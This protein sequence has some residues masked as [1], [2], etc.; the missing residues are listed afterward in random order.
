VNRLLVLAP[1]WLGDVVMALPALTA[2]RAWWPGAH[3][4][5]AA[6]P[7]VAPLLEMIDG[8][9]E[10]IALERPSGAGS[11][12]AAGAD[13]ARLAAGRFE[14]VVLLP[15]SF[16]AAWLARQAG[17]REVWGFRTSGRGLLLTRAVPKPPGR[18][19]QAEYYRALVRGL[20][21]PEAPLAAALTVS[22]EQRARAEELL[23]SR[24]WTGGPIVS[25][26]PGAAYGLA[27]RWPPD[28]VAAVAVRLA[29]AR[30]ATPVL[31]GAPGDLDTIQEV[32]AHIERLVG[33]SAP[34]AVDLGGRTDLLTL[35][36]VLAM[37]RAVVSNDSGAMHVAA[38]VGVPVTAIFG[39]TNEHATAP[40]AH[41]SGRPIALVA[42]EAWCRPCQL[43]ICPIDHRCMKTIDPSRVAD[44]VLAHLDR[45]GAPV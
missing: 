12:V 4:A 11:K 16:H 33:A 14:A 24:G 29:D 40:L 42:G 1:N 7:A 13:A 6:R 37:S 34:A 39:P 20:G 43:R 35:A 25:F 31:V 41:P 23:R 5:V 38:A 18:V 32:L 2:L 8:I 9:D 30:G 21:G 26:A 3:L 10:R 36:G 22:A 15:N 44:T 19:T 28:R 17:I 27:K 45:P